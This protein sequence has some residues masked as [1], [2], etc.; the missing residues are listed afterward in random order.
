[1]KLDG[2]R[3]RGAG[4]EL[5]R[6][7]RAVV[8]GAALP[9]GGRRGHDRRPARPR[10]YTSKHGYPAPGRSRVDQARAAD[11]DAVIVPGGYA[12]DHMRRTPAMVELPAAGERAR[13]RGRRDLPRRL[14][15][16]LG[17]HR[18]AAGAS[19]GSSASRTTS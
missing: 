5:L 11:F 4:G 13:R 14:D 17:R 18:A 15:A 12:P 19:P 8:S 10:R 7:P 16:G 3:D 1:M 6:G 9:R 2:K